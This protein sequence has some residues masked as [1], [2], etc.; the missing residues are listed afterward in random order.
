MALVLNGS[1]ITSAN[2]VNGTIVDEDVA[3]VAASKLTGAL[4][5]IDGSALTGMPAGGKVLQVVNVYSNNMITSTSA[6]RISLDTLSLTP[7][8]SGSRFVINWFLQANWGGLYSGFGA[9]MYRD[10]VEIAKSG[11]EHS[12][13][14]NTI[15]DNYLG[16]SWSCID[17]SGSTAGTAISFE[18]R[19]QPYNTNLIR[20]SRATQTRGFVIMEIAQ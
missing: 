2:L 19:A 12:V 20:F 4:P 18:L 1:G 6:S 14:T 7:V 5:A 9:Y 11:N 15:T 10:G 17:T 8:G 13:Y 3:D 16:G